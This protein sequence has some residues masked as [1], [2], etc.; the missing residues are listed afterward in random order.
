MKATGREC[1]VSCATAHRSPGRILLACIIYGDWA[2]RGN[3][4]KQFGQSSEK[5]TEDE[6]QIMEDSL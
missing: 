5:Y 6:I 4:A 1:P 3:M 2:F